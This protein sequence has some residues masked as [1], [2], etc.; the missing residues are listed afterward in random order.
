M[1]L[2]KARLAAAFAGAIAL[3]GCVSYSPSNVGSMSTLEI[4][5]LQVEQA[6]NLT[7]ESKRLLESEVG[8]RKESC[9]A[10]APAIASRKAADIYRW[11]YGN[12]SP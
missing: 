5:E 9:S 8:R 1:D 6:P 4:C 12:Q 3:T 7:A 11:T 2:R 10:Y